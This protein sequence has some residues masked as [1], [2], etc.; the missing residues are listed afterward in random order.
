MQKKLTELSVARIKPPKT[1]RFEVWDTTLPAFGVRITE[2]DA[3]SWI[4]ALRKPGAK[5]PSRIK[6]GEPGQMKLAE[7]RDKARE[8]MEDPSSLA[9]AEPSKVD[10]VSDVA[11]EFITR[12]VLAN[13]RKRSANDAASQLR[14]EF[15]AHHRGKPIGEIGRRDIL[16]ALDRITDRGHPIAANRLLANLRKFFGWCMERGILEASPVAGIKRP[17]KERSRDRILN[18]EELTAIWAAC[19]KMGWPFGPFVKLLI[20]TGQRR[21][22]VAH[23]AWSDLDLE[24]R[25]WILPR[26]LTKA[27][28]VHE[29][30]LNNLA[31]E[32]IRECPQLGTWVFP[33][34]RAESKNPISGFSKFKRK[35]DRVSAA[36]RARDAG[37]DP[38]TDDF[39]LSEWLLPDWRL[40]DLRRTAASE[41]A[42]LRQPPH[43]IGAILNHSPGAVMGITA[44]YNR[45]RY[46]DE[47]RRAL[48]AWGRELERIIGRSEDAWRN[49]V[50]L[51]G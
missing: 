40:H 15:V 35:L 5:H 20:V 45:H 27:E 11:E 3:R 26:E 38:E 48:A 46:T 16:D 32:I 14:R 9:P 25:W 18:H 41:M 21:D 6:L 24:R 33:A 50:E 39:E 23:M 43:V 4:V 1:G 22:E 37:A 28:R 47:K 31:M 34:N 10:T 49:T 36:Q 29:V 7:A 13:R 30:P 8:L 44:V 12:H 17:A 42:R 2:N 51:G 19:D